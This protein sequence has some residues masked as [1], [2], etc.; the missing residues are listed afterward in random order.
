MLTPARDRLNAN[1]FDTPLN[2]GSYS[3]P[4]V[5]RLVEAARTVLGC[6]RSER[7]AIY[8]QLERVLQDDLPFLFVAAPNEFYAAAPNVIGFAPRPGDPLWNVETWV[9]SP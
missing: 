8:H 9:V 2:Y 7:A 3:N 4:E 1:A 5:T 6:D